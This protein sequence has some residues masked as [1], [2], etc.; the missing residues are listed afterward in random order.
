MYTLILC[1]QKVYVTL[2]HQRE[3]KLAHVVR[4]GADYEI[5]FECTQYRTCC[6]HTTVDSGPTL[7][8]DR[9]LGNHS[10]TVRRAKTTED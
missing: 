6:S 2:T 5:H 7:V 8:S 3:Q 10:T 9:F 1:K 4:S